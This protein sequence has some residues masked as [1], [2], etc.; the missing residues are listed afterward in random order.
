MSRRVD[1][2]E[3]NRRAVGISDEV[4]G[5]MQERAKATLSCSNI[6]SL[7][8]QVRQ[9]QFGYWELACEHGDYLGWLLHS[10]AGGEDTTLGE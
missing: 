8:R 1:R 6:E 10:R 7:E 9:W 3:A 4:W 5:E 2:L